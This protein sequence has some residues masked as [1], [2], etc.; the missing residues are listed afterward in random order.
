M[1]SETLQIRRETNSRL[2][3][4]HKA[5]LEIRESNT[6]ISLELWTTHWM[7]LFFL[8]DL[9]PQLAPFKM[10]LPSSQYGSIDWSSAPISIDSNRGAIS[11]YS[12]I[13]RS[14]APISFDS[15]RGD[16]IAKFTLI[17][18]LTVSKVEKPKI[19]ISLLFIFF[20]SFFFSATYNSKTIRC[21]RILNIPKG[22][23]ATGDHSYWFSASCELRLASYGL[24]TVANMVSVLV[25]TLLSFHLIILWA[26]H[27]YS[28]HTQT[29]ERVQYR[30]QWVCQ[31]LTVCKKK[32]AYRFLYEL[33]LVED[34]LIQQKRYCVY[35]TCGCSIYSE[36]VQQHDITRFQRWV[37]VSSNHLDLAKVCLEVAGS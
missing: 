24:K 33:G 23:Y 5:V 17:T 2:L 16:F 6:W 29:T 1:S 20:L 13:N 26:W 4:P 36:W 7:D 30:Q 8:I 31:E 18:P 37:L 12:L 35:I 25:H 27:V 32:F 22:W 34:R 11:R 10:S 14:S 28:G 9:W 3:I 19:K 21:V 15:N